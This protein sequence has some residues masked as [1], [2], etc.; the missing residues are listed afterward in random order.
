MED[1]MSTALGVGFSPAQLSTLKN[2]CALR[3]ELGMSTG[4]PS[5][6][7]GFGGAGCNAGSSCG[8]ASQGGGGGGCGGGHHG[9]G[10]I[11]QLVD[12]ILYN[13]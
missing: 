10:E 12:P 4:D 9:G 6:D 8:G 11:I 3:K 7:T 5:I 13:W 2:A 1:F